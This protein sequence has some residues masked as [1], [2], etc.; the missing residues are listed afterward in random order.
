MMNLVNYVL[1]PN[2]TGKFVLM[3]LLSKYIGD[4]TYVKLLYRLF[5]GKKCNLDKPETFQEKL[6]WL[7][8]ND[9]KPIYHQMVDKAEAKKFIAERV[10]EQY[11]IPSI[12]VWDCFDEID[13]SLFPEEFIIK[14]THDSGTYFICTDKNNMDKEK[15]LKRLSTTWGKDYY[16]VSR[17]WP[18]KGL[19]QR[20]IAEPLL[21]DKRSNVLTDYKFF[22]FNGEPKFYY[23]TSDR[24]SN[25]GLKEDFFD[26]DGKLLDFNQRGYKNNPN[27]PTIPKNLKKMVEFAR[28]L[29]KDTYHLRVDFYE[30]GDRMYVGEMTFFDGGGLF[31]FV[32]ERYNK[33]LGDWIK[34]PI[35]DMR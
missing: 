13:F 4:R 3:K 22:T 27:T 8:F 28:I 18:Y 35:D 9:R 2:L 15:M 12:G 19:K 6:Q 34:L 1:H 23:T 25:T 17:E 32:P 33:I 14:N 29:A 5:M 26:I 20:I 30:L 31:P 7:K 21:H 11:V 24:G 16:Y 10:G